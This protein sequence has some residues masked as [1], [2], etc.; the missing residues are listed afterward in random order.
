LSPPSPQKD[1]LAQ[2]DEEYEAAATAKLPN[3]NALLSRLSVAI[4]RD[5]VEAARQIRDRAA[6]ELLS[7]QPDARIEAL[8]TRATRAEL[9]ASKAVAETAR[10]KKSEEAL[11]KQVGLL[12]SELRFFAEQA[13]EPPDAYVAAILNSEGET[14]AEEEPQEQELPKGIRKRGER[15]EAL[16]YRRE[17]VTGK[18]RSAGS[19]SSIEEAV[20]ARKAAL[21]RESIRAAVHPDTG[22]R[23]DNVEQRTQNGTTEYRGHLDGESSEWSPLLSAALHWLQETRKVPA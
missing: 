2:E 19:H 21:E 8:E 23:V 7:V 18:Q 3:A 1:V 16:V 5:T 4:V 13:G 9:Q 15:C 6:A 22:Q 12:A 10:A 20:A 17:T 11:L 14:P